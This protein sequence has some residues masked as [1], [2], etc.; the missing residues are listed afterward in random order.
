M[1]ALINHAGI[2]TITGL[3][4]LC[5]NDRTIVPSELMRASKT[6]ARDNV[7]NLRW[8]LRWLRLANRHQLVFYCVGM[9]NN[10]RILGIGN[11]MS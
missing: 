10:N 9:A 3:A 7:P 5:M 4:N 8:L 1:T 11:Y 6:I 2:V